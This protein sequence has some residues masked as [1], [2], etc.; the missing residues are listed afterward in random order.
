MHREF[1]VPVDKQKKVLDSFKEPAD[2]F[3]RSYD[4]YACQRLFWG[5]LFYF[6]ASAASVVLLPL[7][8][9]QFKKMI[10]QRDTIEEKQTDLVLV[11]DEMPDGI[12]PHE[13]T[14]LYESKTRVGAMDE[15]YF[16]HD[17]LD[18]FESLKRRYRWHP[19]FLYKCLMKQAGYSYIIHR[20]RPKC[21]TTCG[22]EFTYTSSFLTTYCNNKGIM[23][24]N[25]MH[26][27]MFYY[28]LDAFSHFNRFYVWDQYY[29]DLLTS[30]KAQSEFVIALPDSVKMNLGDV[31]ISEINTY[32]YKYYLQMQDGDILKNIADSII[33]LKGKGA[34]ISVRYHPRTINLDEIKR[35][36]PD[37]DLENPREVPIDKS[38]ASARNVVGLNSTVLFQ[39]YVS[40]GSVIIDDV[41]NKDLFNKLK[42]M[43]YMMI[44]KCHLLSEY[45]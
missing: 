23:H 40:G 5:R 12:F 6:G 4:Q 44:S 27:E 43:Q 39:T 32:D 45:L 8:L 24:F 15:F 21:I 36:M 35:V 14:D 38:I 37:V 28:I 33:R 20:Y 16:D 11:A 30:L 2:D 1:K 26:G 41:S 10:R 22:G 34:S 18:F 7:K 13:I 9:R 29:A 25:T 3:E 31:D 19:Y 42:E 17:D